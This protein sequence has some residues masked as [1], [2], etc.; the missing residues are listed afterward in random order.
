M[1]PRNQIDGADDLAV[2][3]RITVVRS[4]LLPA[5]L[6][7]RS[8]DEET[9]GT[10]SDYELSGRG[11]VPRLD[12]ENVPSGEAGHVADAV[13]QFVVFDDL[14]RKADRIGRY[15]KGAALLKFPGK[16]E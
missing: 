14:R 6:S 3:D 10:R 13:D 11:V 8:S 12:D 5:V 15:E 16:F 1:N 9:M 2:F 7:P 4:H